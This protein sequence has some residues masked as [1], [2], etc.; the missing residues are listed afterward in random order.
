MSEVDRLALLRERLAQRGIDHFLVTQPDNRRYLSGFPERDI[1]IQGSAG[2]LLIG[3]ESAQFLTSFLYYDAARA[4]VT[5]LEVVKCPTQYIDSLIQILGQVA[6]GRLGIESSWFT[7]EQHRELTSG[8]QGRHEVVPTTGIVEQ[9]RQVKDPGEIS[10]VAAAVELTDR[11]FEHVA[12]MLRPGL[13]E[14]QVAWE[15]EKY[16]REHGAEGMAFEPAVAA[17]PHSAVPHH[18][19]TDRPLGEGEPIWIDVG[20]RLAGYCGD[21]TRSFCL[22][23]ADERFQMIYD[24]VLRAQLAAEAGLRAGLIGVEGDALARD[25]IAAAGHGDAFGHS[26]GHGIGLAVHEAPR[27]SR[28]GQD[29]LQVGMVASVEPGVYLAGWGGVRIEDVVVIEE[30]GARVLTRA[31]KVSIIG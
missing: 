22:G 23:R 6:P 5:A 21:L 12:A 17:G 25:V 28:L 3:Q 14:K 2:W 13:T 20:A 18:S 10:A 1:S 31:P 27:V 11:A 29:L 4:A 30:G 19:P 8:L 15:L 9:L 16:M 24:L 7:L 26:L